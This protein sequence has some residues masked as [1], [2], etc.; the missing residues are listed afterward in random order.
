MDKI[1]NHV[2]K[3]AESEDKLVYYFSL[4]TGDVYKVFESERKNMDQ[5]QIPLKGPVKNCRK[6]YGRG[7]QGKNIK[8]NI[9]E[10]CSCLHKYIDFNK[11]NTTNIDIAT[12]KQ[13]NTY[14]EPKK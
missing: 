7:Y 1:D 3:F 13:I 12:A 10:M 11:I 9:Y 5:Y 4:L 14:M 6:C 8:L 2:A